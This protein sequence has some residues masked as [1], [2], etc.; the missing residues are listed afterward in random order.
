MSG[1]F[2]LYTCR[3]IIY[4]ALLH[5]PTLQEANEFIQAKFKNNTW[6]EGFINMHLVCYCPLVPRIF[7]ERG[8]GVL[9]VCVIAATNVL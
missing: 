1:D 7:E 5:P 3:S 2:V 9:S 6:S 4:I 8:Y